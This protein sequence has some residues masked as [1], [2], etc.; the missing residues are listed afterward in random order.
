MDLF[1]G[2]ND[3]AKSLLLVQVGEEHVIPLPLG[4]KIPVVV[5]TN[6]SSM[7]VVVVGCAITMTIFIFSTNSTDTIFAKNFLLTTICVDQ[8]LV[9][10]A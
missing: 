2:G 1:F 6:F 5:D 3:I 10:F 4:V 9:L 8:N 7:L